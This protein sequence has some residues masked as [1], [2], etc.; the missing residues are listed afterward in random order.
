[1]K[2]SS[3]VMKHAAEMYILRVSFKL[4]KTI[5]KYNKNVLIDVV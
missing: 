4:D 1:M 2:I 5:I 3:T